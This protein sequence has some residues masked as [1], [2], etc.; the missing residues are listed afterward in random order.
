VYLYYL[1]SVF[2]LMESQSDSSTEDKPQETEESLDDTVEKAKA[3]I[4]KLQAENPKLRGPWL[5]EIELL[6]RAL[7]LENSNERG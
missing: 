6:K 1:D 7:A 5:A 3:F 2:H 4:L